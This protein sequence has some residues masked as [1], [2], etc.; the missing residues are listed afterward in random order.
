MLNEKQF[1][2][3]GNPSLVNVKPSYLSL[4]SRLYPLKDVEIVIIYV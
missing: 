3:Y 2:T 1:M 4:K